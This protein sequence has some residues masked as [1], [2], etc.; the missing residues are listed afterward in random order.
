VSDVQV[1]ARRKKRLAVVPSFISALRLPI[2]AG[3]FAVDALVWRGILLFIGALTD[4]LDGWLA[5][6][7]KVES[8]TGAL[9]DPLFD[10]LFVTVALAAFL[11]GPY[12]GWG[13]FLILVSRDLYVAFAFLLAKVRRLDIPAQPRTGG[14]LVTFLQ[15]VTLF[16][17]LLVPERVDVFLVVVGVASAIAILDYSVAWW[18]AVRGGTGA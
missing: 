7:L 12:L 5:R 1:P 11:P 14:K 2:A 16:V 9:L 10:K 3:F 4:V 18:L 17:L 13:G 15:I 8:E 6:R